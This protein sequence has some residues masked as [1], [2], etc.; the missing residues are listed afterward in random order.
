V[1]SLCLCLT[2]ADEILSPSFKV[3][4]VS[5]ASRELISVLLRLRRGISAEADLD[6]QSNISNFNH[7]A[8]VQQLLSTVFVGAPSAVTD[9]RCGLHWR[10]SPRIV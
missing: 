5:Q 8:I 6:S 2:P 3:K 9:Q 4:P 10:K 7:A 1:S